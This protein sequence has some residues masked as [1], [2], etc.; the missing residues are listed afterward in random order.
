MRMMKWI[1]I[2]VLLTAVSVG[3]MEAQVLFGAHGSVTNLGTERAQVGDTW[4]LGARLGYAIALAPSTAIVF[5]GVGEKFFPPCRTAECD[6]IGFQLNVLGTKYYNESTR[7]YAG[8]GFSYQ[9][10]AIEDDASSV[11]VDDDAFGG[12]LI[13][14][15]SFVVAPSFQPFI[16]ARFS[17]LNGLREQASALF[18][19]RVIPGV[20]RYFNDR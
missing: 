18:G 6:L 13:I 11:F 2:A 14:G 1:G 17:A 15:V 12:N 10:F 16:E 5:E 9:D 20:Q 7:A 4:G 3:E 8:L 19:F